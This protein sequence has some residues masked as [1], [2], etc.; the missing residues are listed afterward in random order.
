[1]NGLRTIINKSV[2]L[3]GVL[4]QVSLS[5]MP[6]IMPNEEGDEE[7]IA[8]QQPAIDQPAQTLPQPT[9]KQTT[10]TNKS[11]VTS[12][13]I[14]SFSSEG[15]NTVNQPEEKIGTSGNWVKKKDFLMRAFDMQKEIEELATQIQSYRSIYQQKFN[16]IDDQL[17]IFYKQLGLEQGKVQ[18]LFSQ[19]NEYIEKKKQ[20]KTARIKENIKDVRE[21]QLAVEQLEESLKTNKDTLEQLKADMKSIEDL[22]KS[23]NTR[24]Q[25]ADEQIAVAQQEAAR[26]QEIVQSM[27]DMIDDKRAKAAYFELKDGILRKLQTINSYLQQDLLGD[28]EKVAGTIEAQIKKTREEV[29]QL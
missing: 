9:A 8:V 28:L 14:T 4:W 25:K 7:A 11:N 1:M 16:A 6:E 15:P 27:W 3:I 19:L 29:K 5:A 21:Q 12:H 10:A 23:I 17:D 2:L 26:T 13:F 18:G 22:D 20:R 24:L